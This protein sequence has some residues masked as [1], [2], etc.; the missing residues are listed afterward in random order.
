[1]IPI[2]KLPTIT[3]AE[4]EK[5]VDAFIARV[6]AEGGPIRILAEAGNDCI[7]MSWS[8]YLEWMGDL[9]TPEEIAEIEEGC[10]K[11]WEEQETNK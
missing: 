6:L 1:M 7:I 10:R 9:I 3:Q 5:D 11:F 4:M 8:R 2:E